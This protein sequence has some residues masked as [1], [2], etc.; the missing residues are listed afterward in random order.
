MPLLQS[1]S[2]KAFSS[3]ISEV[4]HSYRD[5]GTIGKIHP[6]SAEHARKI[7]IAIAY[8][9]RRAAGGKG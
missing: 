8:S 9:Q 7:A 6:K 3:N 2:K 4:I 1:K 5:K